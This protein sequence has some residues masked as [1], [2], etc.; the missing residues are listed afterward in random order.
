MNFIST[1]FVTFLVGMTATVSHAEEITVASWNIAN[2]AAPGGDLRGYA[3]DDADYDELSEIITSLNADIIA[4]QEIGSIPAAQ[5]VL[6]P[7]YEIY[8]ESRCLNNEK[9]CQSDANDI[10]TAIAYRNE[11][12]DKVQVF[13][14]DALAIEHKDR[15]D[16]VRSV[17]GGVGAKININGTTAWIPSLHLKATCKDDQIEPGTERDCKTQR[18]QF[19]ILA[20]WVKD[21]PQDDAVILAG[22][23]NRKLLKSSDS[24]RKDI[25]LAADSDTAFLPADTSK[26]TCWANHQYDFGEL[27]QQAHANNPKFKEQSLKPWIYK[28]RS[29]AEIDF[30]VVQGL[31]ASRI[32][33]TRQIPF[34]ERTKFTDP[35]HAIEDCKG[36][37]VSFGDGDNRALTFGKALPSDHCPIVITVR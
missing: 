8:F 36:N 1:F 31:E 3:R 11:L 16:V 32:Q 9:Q 4:L 12:K 2:L 14:I 15:C 20:Q 34:G 37:I 24:I 19:E 33:S 28:P 22:D 18:K 5:R 7:G 25:F 27:T 35:G 6:G 10:Y 23:F 13:Q 17:R 30:F 29:N 26:R 21:L